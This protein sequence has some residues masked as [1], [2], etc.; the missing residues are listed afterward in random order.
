MIQG[1]GEQEWQVDS[2]PIIYALEARHPDI[3]SVLPESAAD[4]FL[5]ELI[6]DFADE[7]LTKAMFIIAG[8]TPQTGTS[9]L[10]G[11]QATRLSEVVRHAMSVFA[12]AQKIGARQVGRMELVGCT[13]ANKP[14]IEQTY[15]RVLD[16][17]EMDVG[18]G[19]FLFGTRPSLADFGL[20]RAAQN[21]G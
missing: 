20:F 13:P 4:R 12:F 7:W 14:I 10:I 8:I 18:F 21:A 6:E 1:P 17:L 16:A 19:Q 15:E 2:T 5:A 11:L 9:A 3:R